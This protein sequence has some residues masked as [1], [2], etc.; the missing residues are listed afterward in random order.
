M[1]VDYI[2]QCHW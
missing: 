1:A 2:M